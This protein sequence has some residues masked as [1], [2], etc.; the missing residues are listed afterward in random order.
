MR[1]GARLALWGAAKPSGPTARDYVQDG[2]VAM[3]DGI[4]NAGWGQH[5][6]SATTWVDLCGGTSI[7][8]Y[9]GNSDWTGTALRGLPRDFSG[10]Y[11]VRAAGLGDAN[12][13]PANPVTAEFVIN[14]DATL[15]AWSLVMRRDNSG[16][17]ICYRYEGRGIQLAY[18]ND[19]GKGVIAQ[20]DLPSGAYS[21]ARVMPDE[22]TNNSPAQAIYL[23]GALYSGSAGRSGMNPY[24]RFG[25]S[26]ALS[27][28]NTVEFVGLVHA[29]RFYSR[30]LTAA[31]IAANYAVDKAR[32]NLP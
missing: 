7:E 6:D 23:N 21:V 3:W 4:E 29:M 30:A 15:T 25:C 18:S 1:P 26:S 14:P 5:D 19:A 8:L 2:L 17:L 13:I 9:A 28:S 11:S 10:G 32:F 16:Q 24:A 27:A 20:G 31:E 12:D 22:F